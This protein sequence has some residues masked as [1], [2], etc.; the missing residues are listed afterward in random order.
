M[1]L[2]KICKT[3]LAASLPLLAITPSASAQD[4][5]ARLLGQWISSSASAFGGEDFDDGFGLYLGLE[6]RLNDRWGIEFGLGVAE[7]E[8][9]ERIG[10][11]FFGSS[12]GTEVETSLQWV[13]LTVAAN[14][15]LTPQRDF[16]LYIAPRAGVAL[17][18]DLEIAVLVDING[19][20]TFPSF[21]GIPID[22][23][24]PN[25]DIPVQ[26][27]TFAVDDTFIYGARLGFDWP[28]GGQG[29]GLSGAVD[30]TVMELD[31]QGLAST[32]LDPL[33]VSFGVSKRW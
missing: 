33:A 30:Y 31:L 18:D 6:R 1:T 27:T 20:P 32:D 10:F 26:T 4:W 17:V 16:D 25:I 5:N 22:I 24:F 29:W 8:A 14:F 9:K 13:P 19:F 2:H 12:F 21:P 7:L 15:H 3:L 28:L 23:D 11:D